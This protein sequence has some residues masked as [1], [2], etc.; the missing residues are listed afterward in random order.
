MRRPWLLAPVVILSVTACSEQ[1]D[2]ATDDLASSA[3]E[4]AVVDQLER[5]GI[6][7][8]DAP[9]CS[10]DFTRD[11][12]SLSGGAQCDATSDDG[13]SVRAEFDG[14]LSGS[15]CSGS[16]AVYVDDE[17]VAQVDEIPDCSINL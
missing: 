14:S 1:L 7:L 4:Q 13:A 3:L 16:L 15:G 5:A 9:E 8:E 10:T 12:T 6:T 2:Q 17:S 11:G